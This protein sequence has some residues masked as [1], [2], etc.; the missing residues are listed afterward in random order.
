MPKDMTRSIFS[1]AAE[2]RPLDAGDAA[3][4]FESFPD[5]LLDITAAAGMAA[6]AAHGAGAAAPFTCGIVNAKSG[7]CS[8]N[9]AFCSQSSYHKTNSPVYGL[10]GEKE[11]F[12]RAARLDGDGVDFMGIVTSGAGPDDDDFAAICRVAGRIRS[13]LGIRLCASLGVLGREKARA[14]KDA[15]F[16]SY[17]HNLE[18]GEAYYPK[19]CTTHG[20]RLRYETVMQARDAGLRV[21]SG[22]IFGLGETL[23]DRLDLSLALRELDVD[24]IP[25]NF[26]TPIPGTPL[27]NSAGLRADEA[28]A[29]VALFRLMHPKRDIVICGGRGSTF[30]RWENSLFFAGANG[31]MVGDYLTS[32][33][34]SFTDDKEMLRLL[35]VWKR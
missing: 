24:C 35:G 15:G 8:E 30:G 21:C 4:L 1:A 22:G 20:W 9:C 28:L 19:I 6:R 11:L 10:I 5:N 32:K 2:G 7:R 3:R 17:H 14:L 13:K 26:L 18:T 27:E 29:V 16:T 33:G 12:E 23:K 34:S 25:L 31:L